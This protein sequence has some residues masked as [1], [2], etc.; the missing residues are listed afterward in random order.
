MLLYFWNARPHHC[1]P[2]PNPAPCLA[3]CLPHADPCVVKHHLLLGN[4]HNFT[5]ICLLEGNTSL[6]RVTLFP[7]H[8]W[9]E[10]A[11]PT[12]SCL[13][14]FSQKLSL[15]MFFTDRLI[16]FDFLCSCGLVCSL[17][18]ILLF[19]LPLHPLH[20]QHLPQPVLY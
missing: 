10:K 17:T 20:P 2:V 3:E 1:N 9:A 13:P 18:C 15:S 8:F 19:S 12:G 7:L 11:K 4:N 5:Q 14:S 6:S 16:E